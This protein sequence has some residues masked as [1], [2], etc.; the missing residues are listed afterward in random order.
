MPSQVNNILAVNNI[1]TSYRRR[2]SGSIYVELKEKS[3]IA[4]V[5]KDVVIKVVHYNGG[6]GPI[7]RISVA[8][9]H[10]LRQEY[11]KSLGAAEMQ[12]LETV[13]GCRLM[14]H[15]WRED[16]RKELGLVTKILK[17]Q[18]QWLEHVERMDPNVRQSYY[19]NITLDTKE[20]EEVHVNDE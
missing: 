16:I 9:E 8:V 12:L 14:D 6:P 2:L 10:P 5:R 17:Y 18:E 15:R 4:K 1:S 11:R 13:V 3:L 20:I 19:W 7:K